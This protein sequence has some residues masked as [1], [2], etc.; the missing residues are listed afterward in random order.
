MQAESFF[1]PELVLGAQTVALG[2]SAGPGQLPGPSLP[3]TLF[4]ALTALTFFVL[5][6]VLAALSAFA[7]VQRPDSPRPRCACPCIALRSLRRTPRLS[8]G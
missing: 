3:A 2:S 5:P 1:A 7:L 6:V 4:A 8:R